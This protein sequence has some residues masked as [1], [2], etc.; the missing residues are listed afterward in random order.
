VGQSEGRFNGRGFAFLTPS[1]KSEGH[2]A[3]ILL[4]FATVCGVD[5]RP[6]VAMILLRFG[7]VC[8]VDTRPTVATI[9]LR[10][11]TVCSVDTWP[12]VA[13]RGRSCQLCFTVA[14]LFAAAS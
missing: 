3:T 4:R 1:C 5:T 13:N 12:T 14:A 7:T 10:F 9:L 6:T 2:V 11:D 8:G